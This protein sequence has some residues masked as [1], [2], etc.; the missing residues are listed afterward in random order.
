MGG[1]A[2]RAAFGF[3]VCA[4]ECSGARG[5][6]QLGSAELA[7]RGCA[8]FG[9]GTGC[10]TPGLGRPYAALMPGFS[11]HFSSPD[12]GVLAPYFGSPEDG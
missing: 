8:P 12:A 1:L 4:A 5:L 6:P 11:L 9:G 2:A 7:L 3:A 10:M